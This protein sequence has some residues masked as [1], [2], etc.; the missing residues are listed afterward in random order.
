MGTV[1][2]S[3]CKWDRLREAYL[4][5]G[6]AYKRGT[7]VADSNTVRT[8]PPVGQGPRLPLVYGRKGSLPTAVSKQS[9]YIEHGV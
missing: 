1:W 2:S 8:Q 7:Q 3:C 5:K 6:E 9:S 4:L